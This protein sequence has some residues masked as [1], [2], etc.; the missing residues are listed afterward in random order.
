MRERCYNPNQKQF[1]DYGGRGITVCD[2]WRNSFEN[3]YADMGPRPPGKTLERSDNSGNYEPSNCYW[4][5]RKEQQN[6]TRRCHKMT[7]GG[8]TLNVQQWAEGLGVSHEVL[9]KRL[10]LGW[11]IEKILTTPIM[12]SYQRFQKTT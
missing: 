10:R 2:R 4:A 1:A 9:R 11:P 12:A 8:K 6:N 5:T 3:F 7:F